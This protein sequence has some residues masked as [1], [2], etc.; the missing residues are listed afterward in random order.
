VLLQ[1][2]ERQNNMTAEV[3]YMNDLRTTCL[4]IA[5]GNQIITDAPTDNHGKGEAFSPTDLV[6]TSL[7]ACMLTVMGIKANQMAININGTRAEVTKVMYSEPRRI[8][9]INVRIF[10]PENGFTYKEKSILE[11]TGLTCPVFHSLH[12]ELLKN[13]A[14]EW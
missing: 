7:A 14:F 4:H 3:N 2:L 13:I 1:D 5:S 6:A 10:F 11:H 8:G 12:P 9:E